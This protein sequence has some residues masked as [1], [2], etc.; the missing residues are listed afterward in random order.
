MRAEAADEPAEA[1]EGDEADDAAGAGG[2]RDMVD[3]GAEAWS[4]TCAGVR[5]TWSC[6]AGVSAAGA[7]ELS[8]AGRVEVEVALSTGME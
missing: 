2:A 5:A 8:M 7:A 6:T 3:D 4:V 1:D